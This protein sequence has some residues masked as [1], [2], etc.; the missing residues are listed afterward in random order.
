MIV[1]KEI[2]IIGEGIVVI[3]DDP[4]P[5]LGVHTIVFNENIAY[6]DFLYC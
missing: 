1:E 2:T 3:F 4:M 5:G 6:W